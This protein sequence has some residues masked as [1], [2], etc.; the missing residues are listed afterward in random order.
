MADAISAFKHRRRAMYCEIWIKQIRETDALRLRSNPERLPVT[1]KTECPGCLKKVEAGLCVAKQQYLGWAIGAPINYVKS[2]R[3][4]PF[5]AHDLYGRGSG[6][7]T[8]F[9]SGIEIFE[10][11]HGSGW[12]DDLLR[13]AELLGQPQGQ[14]TA[15]SRQA[16]A[17]IL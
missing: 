2:I 6:Q 7:P 9:G 16:R 8:Y 11:Q 14:R 15:D 13:T 10:A 12:S 5:C 4:G 3:A 17:R 1:I